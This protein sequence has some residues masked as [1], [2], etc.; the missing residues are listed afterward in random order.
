[1]DPRKDYVPF[2][3]DCRSNDLTHCSSIYGCQGF[4][5]D[6]AG[7][8]WGDDFVIRNGRWQIGNSDNCY[9]SAP[10]ATKLSKVMRKDPVAALRLLQNR[11]RILL[12]RGIFG[13]FV[14]CEDLETGEF[15]RSL[16]AGA[17]GT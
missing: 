9:D 12:T 8:V 14:Y 7:L 11:Y 3:V 5:T 15:L 6:Y 1:M 2:W 13:T 10:G 16:V 4:E 17:G